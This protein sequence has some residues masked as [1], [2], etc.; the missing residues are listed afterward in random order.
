M[1]KKVDKKQLS[2]FGVTPAARQCAKRY[3]AERKAGR[4]TTM[5]AVIKAFLADN[6]DESFSYIRR[7]L[8]AHPELWK[9]DRKVDKQA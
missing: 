3:T 8:T 9:V 2:T 4:K 5:E 6:P 1:D 7:T